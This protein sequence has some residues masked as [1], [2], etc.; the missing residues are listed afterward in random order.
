MAAEFIRSPGNPS[1]CSRKKPMLMKHDDLWTFALACYA[2]PGVE[3]ACLE[4]QAAGADIC[5]LLAG[6]WMEYRGIACD[7]ERLARVKG[8][9]DD[10]R[11]QVVAPLR[12]LRQDWRERSTMDS[13][14]TELRVR[15]KQLELDAEHV[16]L[17]RLQDA[18]ASWAT[19]S[20]ATDWLN[21]LCV[22]LSGEISAPLE[23]MRRAAAVQLAVGA[24]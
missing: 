3:A 10:W 9:S 23:T 18:T 1:V 14:L 21:R 20:G 15:V 12:H 7:G 8:I 17:R 4:L 2:Q 11:I 22:D 16:Q 19:A 13:D 5:L 6:A 24:D